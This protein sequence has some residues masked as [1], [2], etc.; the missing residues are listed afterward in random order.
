[1]SDK[2]MSLADA[3][4]DALKAT[5]ARERLVALFDPDSFVEV[6]TLVQTGC[7]GAAA[8]AWERSSKMRPST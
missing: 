8:W 2:V 6:G 3:R 1:M 7:G 4:E 5:A